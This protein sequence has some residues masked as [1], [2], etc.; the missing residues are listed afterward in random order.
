[1]RLP[2]KLLLLPPRGWLQNT[3]ESEKGW[4][5]RDRYFPTLGNPLSSWRPSTSGSPGSHP[6]RGGAPSDPHVGFQPLVLQLRVLPRVPFLAPGKS[7]GMAVAR[8]E[9]DPC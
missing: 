3:L 5:S 8:S 2:E 7:G 9:E 4:L 6:V 1:M